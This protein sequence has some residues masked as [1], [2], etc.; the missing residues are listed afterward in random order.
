[1]SSAG[2]VAANNLRPAIVAASGGAILATAI[3]V[4]PVSPAS[5]Q[6]GQQ[7]QQQQQP[8]QGVEEIRVTGSRIIRQDFT[9][10]APITTVDQSTFQNTATVGVASVLNQ[11]PQFVPALTQFTTTDVQQTANNTIGGNF[12]SLRGLGPNRNLVLIDGKRAQPSNP[13]M[14]V[15]TNMIPS[16]AIQRVEIISGGASAVY[17]ADAVGGVVN[18][19]L[20]DNFEGASV[21]TRIGDTQHGGNQEVLISG[22][23]GAN[24]GDRG[25]VM[26]GMEH[27]TRSKQYQQDRDWRVAD[28]ANPATAA[29]AFGWGSDTWITSTTGNRNTDALNIFNLPSQAFVNQMF[30]EA[31][32]CTGGTTAGFF[33][34]GA[35]TCPVDANGVNLG[36]PNNTSFLINRNSGT[37]YTGLM[38]ASGA[39]GSYRYD[40]PYDV[41][42][43]GNYPGLPFRVVQPDG[44]IKENNFFQWASSPLERNS[45]F[46]KGHFDVTD[47]VRLTAQA[48]F[49]RTHSET[50]LGLT[51]DNITFWGAPI[52]FGDALYTGDPARAI[53]SSLNGDGTTNAAYIAGGQYGLNCPPTGG[54]TKSQAFPLPPEVV[55][56]F[57]SRAMPDR[58][59]WLNRS[60]DYL[61]NVDGP[62]R[63]ENTT[64]TS[65]IS[66]GLE[67]DLPSGKHHWDVSIATGF[68]DNLTDQK[69]STRLSTYRDVVTR[70]N[71]GHGSVF[72]PNPYVVGF[73][74]SIPTCTS[75]LPVITDFPISE[76][77]V[78]MLTPDLKNEEVIRQNVFE[79]NIAGDLAQMAAGPL[80]YALGT[81]YR[82]DSYDFT[83]DNLSLNENFV[84]P[85]A[86]LFPNAP[87]G[88]DYNVT[89]LYGELL[90]PVI[91]DGPKGVEHFQFELGG[92]VSDW[93]IP[94]V[95]TV[96]SY[97]ALIDWGI[98]PKYRLRGGVNRA[99]RAPNLGELFIGR[100]Q[101]FGAG[102][103]VFGDQCSELNES[104]PYS[105]NP[106]VAGAAQAA[107][108]KAI[109]QAMMGPGGADQYYN[110]NKTTQPTL[111]GVGVQN[112]FGNPNLHEEQADTF[113]LGVVMNILDKWTL[114][115]DYYDIEVKDMIAVEA[116]D[117]VYQRCLSLDQNPTGDIN[118]P[119]CLQITRNPVS[120]AAANIDETYTNQGRARVS[121]VDIQLN[122]STMVAGGGFNINSVMNYNFKSETQDRPDLPTKDWAGTSSCALQI[123]CQGYDY[124]IFTTFSFFRGPWSMSLRHQ[125]WPSI[126]PGACADDPTVSA[127]AC[128][129]SLANGG[130]VQESYQLFALSGS[131]RIGDKYTVRV[132][133]ENLFDTLPPLTGADPDRLPFA[134]PASRIG[135]GLGGGAGA[136]YDPLGR[137]GFVSMTMD[138]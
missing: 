125:Y 43:Y 118:A 53:P 100:T 32:P 36:V 46:A 136:T 94:G 64:T 70:P 119:A 131:Y 37:V 130:G 23:I 30:S 61:R 19:I 68:T 56:L 12:V 84:D 109:C 115:L 4:V 137:R 22:L 51:A 81:T 65:Q 35:G 121:G 58:D 133:I 27:A 113:T 120:G 47:S 90:I 97:K 31:A 60:P 25:N 39:A 135:G 44:T 6:E 82:E 5:A 85:I 20:K 106:A 29:T 87:S 2:F 41:D 79:A 14:F 74:E 72:D 89:E 138:F 52:P 42:P 8:R 107:H 18:F 24:T 50:S 62:R 66:L 67:G 95:G 63:G 40:G 126:L 49:S 33:G 111:G 129:N 132:G 54:C 128:S 13:Q 114:S 122:W 92:R 96:G 86:G 16:A 80:S 91:S 93:S 34:Y 48:L 55:A 108:T 134:R 76:D 88:G 57:Q 124:R 110:V 103:A 75:G 105:A 102:A 7:Q 69:G 11:M 127:T 116:S 3:A 45:A 10:N 38:V 26:L 9:A 15:D 1:M 59:V 17:G 123:Q 112:S 83:P 99:L 98:T 71:Y 117:S 28:M 21:E 77:C 104:G 73:A 101:I 78:R